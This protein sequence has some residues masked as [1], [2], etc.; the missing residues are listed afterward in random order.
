MVRSHKQKGQPILLGKRTRF[1]INDLLS[2]FRLSIF[3]QPASTRV[4]TI[5]ALPIQS[6]RLAMI[7]GNTKTML[8]YPADTTASF[9]VMTICRGGASA[10]KRPAKNPMVLT[11]SGAT[12]AT[13]S[14]PG[15][16]S[17]EKVIVL[18]NALTG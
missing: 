2:T 5:A 9:G 11:T 15:M 10:T 16:L 17:T 6:Y 1:A 13:M 3:Q 12:I 14:F 7:L 8:I 18:T 4:T